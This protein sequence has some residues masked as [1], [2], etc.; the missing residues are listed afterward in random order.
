MV[1][2][3]DDVPIVRAPGQ[4]PPVT[5]QTANLPDLGWGP[6]IRAPDFRNDHG[7]AMWVGSDQQAAPAGDPHMGGADSGAGPA[8]TTPQPNVAG[9]TPPGSTPAP[10][11]GALPGGGAP[12]IQ[13]TTLP[14]A[15]PA[16]PATGIFD[17]IPM[18]ASAPANGAQTGGPDFHA[19]GDVGAWANNGIRSFARGVPV[20]GAMA[21]E[22]DA[23][24]NAGLAPIVEPFLDRIPGHDKSF[25]VNA[26]TF[27]QRYDRAVAMQHGLD[28]TWDADH[29]N[30]S[31]TGK[32]AGLIS[33]L[34][35]SAVMAPAALAPT[36]TLLKAGAGV[37]P[38]MGLG[39][40]DGTLIG[41]AQGYAS[42]DGG[43]TDQSRLTG[44]AGGAA[45]GAV[46]GAAVPAGLTLGK[47]IWGLTGRRLIDA[48]AGQKVVQAPA[49]AEAERLAAL[50]RGEAPQAAVAGPQSA[51]SPARP[52]LGP[53]AVSDGAAPAEATLGA[54]GASPSIAPQTRD[55]LEAALI[56][57]R[58]PKVQAPPSQ[59]QAAYSRLA[60]AASRSGEAPEDLAA[61]ATSLGPFGTLGDTSEPL[62][63]LLRSAVNRPG[64]GAE[65]AAESYF[66]RQVG[67]YNPDAG[68]YDIR[69]SSMR[70]LDSAA[71]GLGVPG[72]SYHAEFDVLNAAQQKAAKPLYDQ[73]R[74]IGPTDSPTLQKLE[75]RPSVQRAKV[76]A[77]RI[78]KEEGRD[79]EGLGLTNVELPGAWDSHLPPEEAAVASAAKVRGP[80]KA[81]SQGPSLAKFIADGGGIKGA[82]GE[83]KAMDAERWHLGKAF[84]RKLIGNGD[85][86]DGWAQRAQEAGYF[87][88]SGPRP[89]EQ[90]LLDAVSAEMRGNPRYAREADQGAMDRFDGR[91]AADEL[92]YRGGD[93][94]D[95]PTEADYTGRPAPQDE[96]AWQHQP[97]A[98]TWDF[99]K[100]GLDD[101]LETYRDKTTGRLVLDGEGRNINGTLKE[102]RG[103]LVRLNPIY[104]KALAA[105][106]GPAA[107][108]DALYAGRR[109]LTEDAPDIWKRFSEMDAGERRMYRLGALQALKDKL[110]NS[111]VTYDASAK[112]GLLQPNQLERFKEMFPTHEGFSGFIRNLESERTMFGTK[113]AAFGNSTT[114][115]Q[116]AH[117]LEPAPDPA[118][119]GAAKVVEGA[120][121]HNVIAILRG[122]S[123]MGG[124]A[125]MGEG[126]AATLA[127]VL[128][129]NNQ[130][131]FPLVV[132]KMTQAQRAQRV[133]AALEKS[134]RAGATVAGANAGQD[135]V[136]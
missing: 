130:K 87:P 21:D 33:S 107:M 6:G 40:L 36:S 132:E 98:E 22:A 78:A 96:P 44:G 62:R 47:G 52:A 111:N 70:I 17:D 121:G 27:A 110:G 102:L 72:Q 93:P 115:K 122:L 65:I 32:V 26:P 88:K 29:P 69:P 85:S 64:Q 19:H 41:G 16:N 89:T 99:I 38:R 105:Y 81:P 108:K 74:E 60:R 28:S 120:A 109:A 119:E 34:V 97:T 76:R 90:D 7:I 117:L 43:W 71:E 53:A 50:L 80:A 84:Q 133:A 42:G 57:A 35:G 54:P 101:E 48:L 14:P 114:A 77:Y 23:I 94:H 46:L 63:D 39:A 113:T 82:D 86:A 9:A 2:P 31:K 118:A 100:R 92:A 25:D 116:L 128:S 12:S 4:T 45:G 20:L 124:E 49:T 61:K 55:E 75:Q 123:K 11:A 67:D 136:H 37:L 127:S 18:A 58:R 56:A 5:P 125:P 10:E 103:E 95:A 15:G 79:A 24:T 91:N 112:A 126:E 134:L 1:G 104:G 30:L 83:I 59:V 68:A 13:Q 8:P 66:P 73:V 135:T 131:A 3:F 51:G 129:S 106:S